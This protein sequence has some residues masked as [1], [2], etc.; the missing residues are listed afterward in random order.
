MSLFNFTSMVHLAGRRPT[1][2]LQHEFTDWIRAHGAYTWHETPRSDNGHL[3]VIVQSADRRRLFAALVNDQTSDDGHVTQDVVAWREIDLAAG[4]AAGDVAAIQ[5]TAAV[6]GDLAFKVQASR[7][8]VDLS[9]DP[10]SIS[11]EV[12]ISTVD[13][14]ETYRVGAQ[15]AELH[16]S[17]SP[18][19]V[20]EIP[21]VPP[22]TDLHILSDDLAENELHHLNRYAATAQEWVK[23]ATTSRDKAFKIWLKAR[24][25]L[26]Y[27]ATVTHIA[28]FTWADTLVIDHLGWRGICDEWAVVQVTMLR[29]VGI[30]AR[31]KFL[32]WKEPSGDTV[33]HA[34]VE[35][36]DGNVWRHMDALWSAFDRPSVYRDV[37]KAQNVTVMDADYPLDSRSSVP[38]WGVP[39]TPGD[40]KL[41]PYG[42][43]V[44]N[45]SYPGNARPG[46]S[47]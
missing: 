21:L 11:W 25:K 14:V 43:F 7:P 37:A 12:E 23:G 46:Y 27:D 33:G 24:Q 38:A 31:M 16:A 36:K 26:A 18:P 10:A 30:P 20:K 9:T 1:L 39:D 22:L 44:I 35:W 45:P 13:K 6:R 28:E 34:C 19:A 3:T 5:R 2:A 41:Y 42:D 29:A 15:K 32:I 17:M 40:L 47:Y 8:V 4:G